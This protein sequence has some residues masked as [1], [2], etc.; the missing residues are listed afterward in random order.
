MNR[1]EEEKLE[2][3]KEIGMNGYIRAKSD[4]SQFKETVK[5]IIAMNFKSVAQKDITKFLTKIVWDKN[6]Y[7]HVLADGSKQ[8]GDALIFSIMAS[9]VVSIV[10]SS[11]ILACGGDPEFNAVTFCISFFSMLIFIWGGIYIHGFAKCHVASASLSEYSDD[12]PYDAFLTVK[13]AE[14]R[15]VTNF[16]IYY[17]CMPDKHVRSIRIHGYSVITGVYNG[18]ECLIFAWNDGKINTPDQEKHEL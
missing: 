10:F 12:M 11:A 8:L 9:V 16:K 17:Q 13:E 6:R 14:K 15:G 4:E 7:Y 3:A 18:V 2:I 5:E 1:E